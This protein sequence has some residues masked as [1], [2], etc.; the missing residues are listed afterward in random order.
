M[1][2]RRYFL[3][4][5]LAAIILFAGCS[6]DETPPPSQDPS[7]ALL[8]RTWKIHEVYMNGVIQPLTTQQS[9]YWVRYSQNAGET[10]KGSSLDKDGFNCV[11]AI[12][13]PEKDNL[14]K[15]LQI[16]VSD[17]RTA[18]LTVMHTINEL[19]AVKLDISCTVNT[20]IRRDVYVAQ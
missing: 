3:M 13:Q 11:W 16:S 6:K 2:K 19:T 1:K 18:S 7:V 5:V 14:S 4:T 15:K 8:T 12:R 9:T 17:P 10:D 20:V